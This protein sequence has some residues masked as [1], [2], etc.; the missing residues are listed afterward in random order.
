M[1]SPSTQ[2]EKP[3]P[4]PRLLRFQLQHQQINRRLQ[5]NPQRRQRPSPSKSRPKRDVSP[6][7]AASI[8]PMS[9]ARGPAEKFLLSIFSPLRNRKARRRPLELTAAAP[10]PACWRSAPPKA[11]PP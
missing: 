6:A 4:F 8:S 11:G 10:S 2:E 1:K 7:N 9:T 5:R 3:P